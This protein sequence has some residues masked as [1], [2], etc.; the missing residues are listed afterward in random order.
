MLLCGGLTAAHAAGDPASNPTGRWITADH[1]AVIQIAPC[2][3]DLCGQIV[4]I[5]QAHPNDP[6]P[7]DWQGQ[8]TCG[9]VILETAP[10]TDSSGVTSWVGSVLDPRDG[11]V[12]H[13]QMVLDSFRHLLLHGYIGLPIFGQTQ[14]W[15]P[16]SGRTMANCKLA[17]ASTQAGPG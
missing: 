16:Y 7:T 2:G 4:G 12:Y 3:T 14:T 13:A 10:T 1:S 9:K 11:A 15:T 6:M 8:P 5:A 17:A